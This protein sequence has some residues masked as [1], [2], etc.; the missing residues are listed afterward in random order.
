M[1]QVIDYL[2][3]YDFTVYVISG[4]KRNF[5]RTVVCEGAHNY[6]YEKR[7]QNHLWRW[8]GEKIIITAPTLCI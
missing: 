7:F 8:G 4:T 1:L 6:L 5:V 3:A 2:K